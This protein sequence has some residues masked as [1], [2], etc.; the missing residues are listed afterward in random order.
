MSP[1]D[2]ASI[3]QLIRLCILGEKPRPNGGSAELFFQETKRVLHFIVD[4]KD[5]KFNVV[6]DNIR[7]GIV[8]F[9]PLPKEVA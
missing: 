6:Y 3:T 2:I 8:T 9:L 7:R 5:Q 4:Y 1:E